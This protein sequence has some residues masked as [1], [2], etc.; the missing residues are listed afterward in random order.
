MHC[1][2]SFL[3]LWLHMRVAGEGGN[4]YGDY[5]IVQENL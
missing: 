5:Y 4:I 1:R 2:T 3:K